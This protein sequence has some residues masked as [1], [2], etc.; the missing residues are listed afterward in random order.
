MSKALAALT[1]EA[2]DDLRGVVDLLIDV[3]AADPEMLKDGNG[4]AYLHISDGS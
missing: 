3:S 1:D 4:D 2:L